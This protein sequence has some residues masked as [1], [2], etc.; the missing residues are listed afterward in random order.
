VAVAVRVG[1]I[2]GVRVGIDG[3]TVGVGVG[4]GLGMRMGGVRL[5]L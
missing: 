4:V 5:G 3:M 1:G 2:G